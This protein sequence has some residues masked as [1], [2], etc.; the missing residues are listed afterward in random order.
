MGNGETRSYV[1]QKDRD[2][3]PEINY[4]KDG[5]RMGRKKIDCSIPRWYP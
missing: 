5:A 3:I 2:G 1:S 4:R